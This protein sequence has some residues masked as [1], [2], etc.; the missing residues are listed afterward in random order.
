[1]WSTLHSELGPSLLCGEQ[2]IFSELAARAS[3]LL[4]VNWWNYNL[5]SPGGVYDWQTF[6]IT[7]QSCITHI[8][9][10]IQ[11]FASY[12]VWWSGLPKLWCVFL[13]GTWL[14]TRRWNRTSEE[15]WDKTSSSQ[16]AKIF[17]NNDNDDNNNNSS[18]N[19]NNNSNNNNNN[20]N[21]DNNNNGC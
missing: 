8:K 19:D 6:P 9:L 17:E 10:L 5:L 1:M 15:K 7:Q 18:N 13:P 21:N 3:Y 11:Y 20:S 14:E 4:S 2:V 16:T 12:L